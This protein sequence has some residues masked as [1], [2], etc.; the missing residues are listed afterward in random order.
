MLCFIH[1]N[2]LVLIVVRF[3][4]GILLEIKRILK[5]FTVVMIVFEYCAEIF[6]I[7]FTDV[8]GLTTA[9]VGQGE[10]FKGNIF[11]SQIKTEKVE[12]SFEIELADRR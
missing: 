9:E 10:I 4:C 5:T 7:L 6:F 8:P 1:L 11:S 2:G 12:Q 3:I